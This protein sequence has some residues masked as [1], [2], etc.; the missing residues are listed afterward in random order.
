MW[1]VHTGVTLDDGGVS[2]SWGR[3]D[4]ILLPLLRRDMQRGDLTRE[5]ALELIECLFLKASE[6]VN[7]LQG[8]ATHAIGGNTS[9]IALTI[10]GLDRQGQDASNELSLLFLDAVEEMKTIQAQ[11]RRQAASGDA[12]GIPAPGVGRDGGRLGEPAGGQ[13]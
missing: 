10:G 6:T 8:M 9:F 5:G 12:R 11:L 7:L 13:R 4:Q 2:Q 3:L 1:F